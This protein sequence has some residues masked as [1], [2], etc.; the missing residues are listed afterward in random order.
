MPRCR[1]CRLSLLLPVPAAALR[2]QGAALVTAAAAV[3]PPLGACGGN[4]TIG[5]AFGAGVGVGL[6]GADGAG[7][8][9]SSSGRRPPPWCSSR[10]R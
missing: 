2:A 8:E 6:C 1:G 5:A 3:L 9:A 4:G 10:C 7:G